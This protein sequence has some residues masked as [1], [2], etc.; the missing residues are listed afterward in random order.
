MNEKEAES[1]Q[2][3][4]VKALDSLVGEHEVIHTCAGCWGAVRTL[5]AWREEMFIGRKEGEGVR[6]RTEGVGREKGGCGETEREESSIL[7]R[8][9]LRI[10]QTSSSETGQDIMARGC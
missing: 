1:L 2:D 8:E 7:S 10:I 6:R 5:T 3:F 4:D 9:I